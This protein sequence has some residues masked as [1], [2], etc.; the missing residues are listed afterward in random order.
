MNPATDRAARFLP[1]LTLVGALLLDL[2]PEPL[3]GWPCLL[4]PVHHHW[5]VARPEWLPAVLVFLVGCAADAFAGTPVGATAAALLAARL[6][7]ARRR[8]WLARR[9]WP[10][11][12]AAFAALA[13]L[14]ALIRWALVA[15]C[16]GQLVPTAPLLRETA[17][18]ILV[19]PLVSG[20][21][22]A[23]AHAPRTPSDAAARG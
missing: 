12:W 7:I 21:L 8:R 23:W 3:A 4:V 5:A 11:A 19:F 22:G 14:V 10:L 13:A 20:L 17:A 6:V 2:L 1:A 16:W 18:T 15:L 9:T